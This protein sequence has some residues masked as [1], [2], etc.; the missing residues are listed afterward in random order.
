MENI[1]LMLGSLSQSIFIFL[2]KREA[3]KHKQKLK[4]SFSYL[5]T[6]SV[7]IVAGAKSAINFYLYSNW[8][9]NVPFHLPTIFLP[10]SPTGIPPSLRT[11][12]ELFLIIWIRFVPR[13]KVNDVLSLHTLDNQLSPS[14]FYAQLKRQI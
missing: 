7:K 2:S 4:H 13:L 11:L 14:C 1:V 3:Y 12:F 5:L 9:S 10:W 6:T 8:L